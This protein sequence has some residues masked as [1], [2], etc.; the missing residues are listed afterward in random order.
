MITRLDPDAVAAVEA[1]GAA[2]EA[3]RCGRFLVWEHLG[4]GEAA[5]VVDSDVDVLPADCSPLAGR[6]GASVCCGRR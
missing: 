2:E 5:V 3:D 4:V 6:V 1:E